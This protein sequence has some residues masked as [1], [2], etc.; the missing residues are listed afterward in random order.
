MPRLALEKCA[1]CSDA[2]DNDPGLAGRWW[3]FWAAVNDNSGYLGAG[4]VGLFLVVFL[5]WG[6]VHLWNKRK[7]KREGKKAAIRI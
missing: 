1:K 4:V 7:E 6:G 5:G 2:A 3:R